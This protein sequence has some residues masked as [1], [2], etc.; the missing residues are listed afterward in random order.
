MLTTAAQLAALRPEWDALWRESGASATRSSSLVHHSWERWHAG[1][2]GS[3]PRCVVGREA[4]RLV[5][6]WPLVAVRRAAWTTVRPL[7]P[8][9][10][11]ATDVLVAG[12]TAA[13]AGVADARVAGAW[14]ALLDHGR[15]D[16]VTLP[17]VRDGSRLARALAAGG[18]GRVLSTEADVVP[19][20]TLATPDAVAE[21]H[22][23]TSGHQRR[24]RRA[25][26]RGLEKHGEVSTEAVAGDDPR[27]AGL[28][29]WAV[30]QKAAWFAASGRSGEWAYPDGY[31]EVLARVGADPERA[32]EW[33]VFVLAVAGEPAAVAV[34][35]V[36]RRLE[37]VLTAFSAEH[38]RSSPGTHLAEHWVGWAA[39]RGLDVDLGVGAEPWKTALARGRGE[40]TTSTVLAVRPWGAVGVLGRRGVA[41]AR[42]TVAEAPSRV[43]AAVRPRRG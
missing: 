10:A 39:E 25:A 16:L 31:D 36:G 14:A 34:G 40:P 19:V 1:A 5:L 22:G 18:R 27:A 35:A 4:G 17:Y 38:A 15:A 30:A 24:R 8:G 23:A 11:E 43:R 7:A 32:Q 6:V 12:T 33:V 3:E 28:L 9:A 42:A 41:R 29:R 13:D 21:H 26:L 20:V 37:L 2:A